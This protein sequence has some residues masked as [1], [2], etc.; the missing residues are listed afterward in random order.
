MLEGIIMTQTLLDRKCLRTLFVW[1]CGA[2]LWSFVDVNSIVL[3]RDGAA[4]EFHAPQ[5][6]EPA[7]PDKT[8]RL[9]DFG[10]VGDGKTLN[11]EAIAKAL[12][13]LARRGGG[14][15]IIPPG[16]W[17]TGPVRLRSKID[18]HLEAGALLQFISDYKQFPLV[19]LDVKGEKEIDSTPPLFGENLEN[20]AI[21]GRGVIDG[22]G[23]AWRPVKK[24][25][26]TETQWKTIINSGGVTDGTGE[27]WWPSREAME[28]E[29]LVRQLVKAQSLKLEDYEPAHQFLRPKLLK[30]INCRRVMFEGVTFQNP[31]SWTLN[32]TLCQEV[33][34][35]NITV[36]NAS[37]AQNSDA[38]DL[39]SCQNVDLRGSSLDAGD[40]GIC[41][42]S[43]KDAAGRRIGV[44]T[45]NVLIENCIVYHAHGGVSIGS[46]MSGGV[47]NIRVNNCLFMGT[48]IGLRFKSTRGRGGIVEKIYIHNVRMTD[49][50]GEA[51]S[52]DMHYTGNAPLDAARELSNVEQKVVPAT[53][54]TPQFR[55]IWIEDLICRGA[56]AA[57]LLQ[58]LPEMPIRGIHLRNI[59]ITAETGMVWMDAENITTDNMEILNSK[60]PVLTVFDTKNAVIDQ[61]GYPPGAEA[62]IRVE[63]GGN[64]GI[65]VTNTDLK[66]AAKDFV[67]GDGAGSEAITVK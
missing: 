1:L 32:P 16:I 27:M 55:D 9:A 21:T 40:D 41:L 12:D 53:E 8:I 19:V 22:G 64:S 38:L 26:L 11:T 3:A 10:G 24:S 62:V 61:L 45:E 66:A 29:K 58:G 7:I 28:G 6:R 34:I 31:P 15:L 4:S 30:L 14:R 51:I 43:G 23:D 54:E 2:G 5:V 65:V 63:G 36:H 13:A 25:K 20:V 56:H 57:V 59:S 48:D 35:R 52:F 44:P 46:E 49:I 60:G 67:F 17:L 39:E 18:L 47:R 42:K 50:G 33:T 37:Y